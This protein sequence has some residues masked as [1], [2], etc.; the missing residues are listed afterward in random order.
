MSEEQKDVDAP[1]ENNFLSL[2]DEEIMKMGSPE[3][4]TPVKVEEEDPNTDTTTTDAVVNNDTTTTTETVETTTPATDAVGGLPPTN[5]AGGVVETGTSTTKEIPVETNK[6][7]IDYKAEYE[8]LMAPFKANGREVAPKSVSDVVSL[9]QMGANY[10]KKMEAMKPNLKIIKLL[11]NNGLLNEEKI[12]F[13]IDLDKKSPEAINKLVN[14]SGINPLDF[15]SDKASS[16]RPQTHRVDDREI[17]LDTVL[18]EI[19]GSAGYSRTLEVLGKEW[20]APSKQV[21]ASTPQLVKVI[22]DHIQSG[23]YDVITT[24]IERERMFGRLKGLSNIEAYRQV[25]DALQSR[26]GFNHLDQSRMTTT[27]PKVVEV[28][29]PRPKA[30]TNALNEKRR[31]AGTTQTKTVVALPN[32]INPLAMS[33]DEFKKFASQQKY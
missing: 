27:A 4:F 18:D 12:S 1:S 20:D 7:P 10:N 2:S 3:S 13:L 16:Y 21:I 33:D 24:E 9:M 15:D 26:G 5:P 29:A 31:A 22:N 19:Q 25:G 32:N 8:K 23:I 6:D 30:D 11:E 28:V 14:D 17:D